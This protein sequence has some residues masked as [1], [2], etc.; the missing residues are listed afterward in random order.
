MRSPK[1]FPVTE[2]LRIRWARHW[3]RKA[4]EAEA[5]QVAGSIREAELLGIKLPRRTPVDQR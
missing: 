1:H 2:A 3:A 5:K 4:L